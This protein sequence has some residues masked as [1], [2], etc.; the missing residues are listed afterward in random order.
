[1][2]VQTVLYGKNYTSLVF[3]TPATQ[4]KPQG[5]STLAADVYSPKG[6]TETKRPLLWLPTPTLPS[7]PS[8]HQ[9]KWYPQDSVC[10][11]IARKFA[12]MGYVA[13]EV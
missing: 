4:L 2:D 12:K 7:I 8:K 6:D 1:M 9:C 10:V 13:A 5:R 3:H 11:D